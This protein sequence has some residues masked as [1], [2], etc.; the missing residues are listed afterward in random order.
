MASFDSKLFIFGDTGEVHF[1]N[2]S[3]NVGVQFYE[4]SH[5]LPD[6]IEI[7]YDVTSVDPAWYLMCCKLGRWMEPFWE[8]RDE[9]IYRN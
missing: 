2:A 5:L 6:P 8:D 7:P 3:L 4:S 1:S 9:R